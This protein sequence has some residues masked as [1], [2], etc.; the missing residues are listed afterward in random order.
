MNDEADELVG[1]TARTRTLIWDVSDLDDPVLAGHRGAGDHPCAAM[2]GNRD[3]GSVSRGRRV[4]EGRREGRDEEQCRSAQHLA[5]SGV[6]RDPTGAGRGPV[7]GLRSGI[8][9]LPSAGFARMIRP[10]RKL[11]S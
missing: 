1:L 8:M 10:I 2:D 3:H 5:V 4:G 9:A 11:L 6:T 7:G